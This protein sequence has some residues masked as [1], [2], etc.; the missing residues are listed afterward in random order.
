MAKVLEHDDVSGTLVLHLLF[1]V[2]VAL[3]PGL[4]CARL[5]MIY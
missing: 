4:R 1:G 3:I 5:V 2:L